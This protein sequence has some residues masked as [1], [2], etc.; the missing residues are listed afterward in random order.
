LSALLD[1]ADIHDECAGRHCLGELGWLNPVQVRADGGE[2]AV[3]G[4]GMCRV[5]HDSSSP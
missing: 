3:D 5:D 4:T 1:R 2:Q